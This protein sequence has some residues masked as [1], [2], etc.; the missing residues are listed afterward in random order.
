MEF[1]GQGFYTSTGSRTLNLQLFIAGSAQIATGAVTVP[2]ATLGTWLLRCVVTTRTTG[3]SGTQIANCMFQVTGATLTAPGD[4]PMQTSATWTVDTTGT[5]A[6]DLKA[7][8]DAT[9]GSPTITATNVAA[10]IPGGSGGGGGTTVTV[11]VPIITVAGAPYGPVWNLATPPTA[12]W[13]TDN[14]GTGSFDTTSG[15]PYVSFPGASGSDQLRVLYRTAPSTPYTVC[16]TIMHDMS[17]LS[18]GTIGADS[19]GTAWRDG[20]GKIIRWGPTYTTGAGSQIVNQKWTAS[21]GATITNYLSQNIE[22][23]GF[24]WTRQ[25]AMLCQRDDGANLTWYWSLDYGGHLKQYDQRARTDFFASGPTQI[26]IAAY[27][28]TGSVEMALI[29]YKTCTEPAT[30][31]CQ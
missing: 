22:N 24:D 4:F 25:P 12:S 23:Y 10:Y 7:T 26:G 19:W 8:W 6:L 18:P 28:N 2:G 17:G 11:A 29:G 1:V 5:I 30:S 13:S 14:L 27:V 21:T 15:Y 9:T 31:T 20:T 3:V 16:Q